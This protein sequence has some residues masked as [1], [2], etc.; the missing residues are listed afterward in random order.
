M[1]NAGKTV[2]AEYAIALA[3]RHMTKA[4]YTSPIKTLSNEK[5]RDFRETFDDV[6]II[7]GD[8]QIKR[9][10]ATLIMTTEI[11]RSLLY[12]KAS[13]I[14]DLEWVIFD[15]C[16]YIND[17]DRGVVWEEVSSFT[18]SFTLQFMRCKSLKRSIVF[19]IEL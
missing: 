8:V 10:A 1:E 7:T 15:E 12:N 14:D 18:C 11:L 2:V 17:A 4:I 3:K 6:G 19:T 9:D 5:F 13:T 16:H